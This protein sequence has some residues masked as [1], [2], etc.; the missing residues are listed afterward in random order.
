MTI[1]SVTKSGEVTYLHEA[2]N[3]SIP[4]TEIATK[5]TDSFG[6]DGDYWSE[7]RVP[8]A[9]WYQTWTSSKT[10]NLTDVGINLAAN[11]PNQDMPITIF[12]YHNESEL[13]A[14][15]FTWETLASASVGVSVPVAQTFKVQNVDVVCPRPTCF[16][17]HI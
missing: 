1:P 9:F 13:L 2:G 12:R 5:A 11:T 16:P 14:P 17:T 3:S 8:Y 7:L 4:T 10:G 6:N 15:F